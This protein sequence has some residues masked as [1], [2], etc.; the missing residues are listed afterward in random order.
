MAF[1]KDFPLSTLHWMIADQTGTIVVE[2]MKDGLHVYDNPVGVMTNNPPFP[3]M[4]FALNDYFALSAHHKEHTF[5]PGV[6]LAE[7]SRGMGGLGLPG[8]LSSKS[9]FVRCKDSWKS[10]W[11]INL[12]TKN[13]RPKPS[14]FYLSSCFKAGKTTV[15]VEPLPSSL[16]RRIV[17]W[18]CCTTCLTMDRPSP[19]PPVLR[20]WDLSTR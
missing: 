4:K 3:I 19:V 14:I 8:D 2:S 5:G 6:E 16:S 7:Y 18:H 13:A 1:S 20:L 12:H 11:T 17:P 9:R 10:T 15:K